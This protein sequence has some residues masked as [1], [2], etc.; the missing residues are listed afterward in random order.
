MKI[1]IASVQVPFIRGGA[2][3]LTTSLRTALQIRGHAADVVTIPF[4]WYPSETLVQCM[5]AG[6]MLDLSEMNG[7]RIDLVIAMKFPAYFLKHDRKVVWLM[8]QHRQAYDLWQTRFGDIHNWPDGET[9]RASIIRHDTV[10]LSEARRIY[11]ISE[12]VRSRL[13]QYNNLDSSAL[14]PPPDGH[15]H[16]YCESYDDFVF[17]P[18][19]IDPMK[20]QRLLIEAARYLKSGMRVVI[21]GGGNETETSHL[22]AL[23]REYNLSS[24][25]TLVGFV[26]EEEKRSYYARCRCV[27]FGGV[28]EDYGYVTLEAFYC[29]KAV[30]T[31]IDT[32]GALE[33]AIDGRNSY[34]CEPDA[35]SV[36]LRLDDLSENRDLAERLG[37]EG[38][39]TL[40]TKCV[41]W[42]H[43]IRSLVQTGI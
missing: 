31:L 22:H 38:Y 25:V 23:I 16:L 29:R 27:F 11:T 20:R 4:K 39:T 6:R 35:R 15:E 7:T 41:E 12:N 19:R 43:V 40:M 3:S 33:F 36:A 8:H 32:G 28:D 21:A 5:I 34:V 17:Y 14:Y 42:D 24:R 2:E 1:A 26:S 13:W 30:V 9:L 18:S 37:A 10:Y